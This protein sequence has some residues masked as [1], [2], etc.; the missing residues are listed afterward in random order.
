[1]SFAAGTGCSDVGIPIASGTWVTSFSITL[2]ACF[3]DTSLPLT[4]FTFLSICFFSIHS[5]SGTGPTCGIVSA[6]YGASAFAFGMDNPF[7]LANTILSW[8]LAISAV[9]T[10]FLFLLF[11]VFFSM[12]IRTRLVFFSSYF[13]FPTASITLPSYRPRVIA[14]LA[15]DCSIA[16]FGIGTYRRNLFLSFTFRTGVLVSCR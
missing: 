15:I 6:G 14:D 4:S 8:H 1:M 9:S 12:T 5:G 3:R 2:G 13:S 7:S 10:W 16:T 11:Y